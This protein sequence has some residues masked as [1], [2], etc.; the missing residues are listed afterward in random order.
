LFSLEAQVHQ[1]Q[2]LETEATL[3]RSGH[4]ELTHQALASV[5]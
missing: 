5:I 1:T 2:S 4:L 3:E